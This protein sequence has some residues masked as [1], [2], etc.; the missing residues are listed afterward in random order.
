MSPDVLQEMAHVQK[1]HWWFAA[2]RKILESVIAD[3]ALPC[4]PKIL[5]LGC[6]PGGNLA[7]LN[8]FGEL[9]A[10]E[11]DKA[12]CDVANS[13]SI[14]NV[15]QGC[16]PAT[17]P[18]P[19]QAFDLVCMLDVLEHIEDDGMALQSAARLLKPAGRLL[20]TV[21][22]YAW[23][24]SAHDE[25]HHHY[26]R[27][28]KRTLGQA[29]LTANLKVQRMGYFNSI[30]FPAIA[31]ARLMGK[32]SGRKSESDASEPPRFVNA[33]LRTIFQMESYLIPHMLFP[34][35]TSVLATLST[36]K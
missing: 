9:H 36:P 18:Y 2:R 25:S 20:V 5:E 6:G 10:M 13:L 27:Y 35:G 17:V 3:M 30:L 12:A 16:L 1:T 4:S 22:A 29:A 26:R 23:L 14:C 8:K 34:F 11:S 24:W 7:M 31:S 15:T 32:L 28:T 21:P 33:T 19:D